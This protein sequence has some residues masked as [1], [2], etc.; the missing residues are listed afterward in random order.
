MEADGAA[1]LLDRF[2][3]LAELGRGGYGRVV[4]A[5]DREVGHEVALKQLERLTPAAIDDFKREFRILLDIRHPNIVRL[6]ELIELDGSWFIAQELV[7]GVDFH[8]FVT[9]EDAVVPAEPARLLPALEQLLGALEALHAAGVVHRD[10]K[11]DNV[12]VT[13]SGRVVLL[14]FGI[15][16]EPS[17][18]ETVTGIH[19]V[20]TPA[21]MAPEQVDGA[22]IKPEADMYSV[23]VMLFEALTGRLPFLGSSMEI[24]IR[25][26][27]GE[28]PRPSLFVDGI[29]P[30]LE[31][32]CLL[33]LSP[34]PAR[35]PGATQA[36][37]RLSRSA[38]STDSIP[39]RAPLSPREVFVGRDAEL[40]L[41]RRSHVE[42]CEGATRA[43]VIEGE[44][45]IGK[46]ALLAEFLRRAGSF[47][48]RPL[49]AR[50][51]CHAA[52]QLRY[53]AFDAVAEALSRKLSR[54]TGA[55][56]LSPEYVALV[57]MLFPTLAT[58]LRKRAAFAVRQPERALM[59]DAFARLLEQASSDQPLVIAIDDLQ[60]SDGDSL[61]LLESLLSGERLSNLL[62]VFT[63]RP[64]DDQDPRLRGQL[65]RLLAL[66]SMRRI[67]LSGLSAEESRT[68]F[69]ASLPEGEEPAVDD[70]LLASTRGHPY[71]IAELLQQRAHGAMMGGSLEAS[72]RRRLAALPALEQEL[73][74]TLAVANAPVSSRVLIRTVNAQAEAVSRA[75]RTLRAER[76]ARVARPGT[77]SSYHD[78]LRRVLLEGLPEARV[79]ALHLALASAQELE[80]EP[81]PAQIAFHLAAAGASER[82]RPWLLR[83][84]EL[85][86]GRAAFGQAIDHASAL[87]AGASEPA[88]R[89]ELLSTRAELL[90][91]LG[92]GREAADDYLEAMQGC[93][94]EAAATLCIRAA[95]QLLRSG[96]VA[97]GLDT[98]RRA[99]KLADLGWSD[100]VVGIVMRALLDRTRLGLTRDPP[101]TRAAP[102]KPDDLIRLEALLAL[103]QPLAWI[104][105]L[106]GVEVT[107]RLMALARRVGHPRYMAYGLHAQAIVVGMEGGREK[108]MVKLL[109]RARLYVE[110]DGSTDARAHHDLT[111]GLSHFSDAEFK[112]AK[113]AFAA[114]EA[115]YHDCPR[116]AWQLANVRGFYLQMLYWLGDHRE[117]RELATR[118]MSDAEQRGD[119][120]AAT[121]YVGNGLGY[122]RH[123]MNDEPD[124]ALAELAELMRPWESSTFG[125]QHF[126][127]WMAEHYI[128]AY[129]RPEETA[130]FWERVRRQQGSPLLLR[131]PLLSDLAR[132]FVALGLLMRR[133]HRPDDPEV[134]R[135][136][137]RCLARLGEAKSPLGR[138]FFPYA[139]AQRAVIEGAPR[140]A[141]RALIAASREA[142][143]TIGHHWL[144]LV[145]LLESHLAG[146]QAFRD[147]EARVV[148]WYRE[149]GWQAPERAIRMSLPVYVRL[150]G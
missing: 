93:A 91:F 133:V 120:F 87:L 9:R 25:K 147:T 88:E 57:I 144:D 142:L 84:L 60:W 100:G 104:D 98:A 77:L 112:A 6:D 45:G 135:E 107:M 31:E 33:L 99:F 128:R 89:R 29:R 26:R 92:R 143:T 55:V 49:I 32:L 66:P 148:A 15:A 63:M 61:Q 1:R 21:Y 46:S 131:L 27:D 41:L 2:E 101:E 36:L 118:W 70:D 64:A 85:A 5:F 68:M 139:R 137:D 123:L 8:S 76:L 3:V 4:R 80:P 134:R 113:V 14:D 43:V 44:S 7:E 140:E 20:G 51:R 24:L 22:I 19:L 149:Q 53:K 54:R 103:S 132:L 11:P 75:T 37:S 40:A 35:R 138:A 18:M 50:G 117:H 115:R 102:V 16:A 82:A 146:P 122:A 141:T 74:Q 130:E 47:T 94:P 42:A 96:E 106:R 125:A 71:F 30:D 109:E 110:R 65:D 129:A 28:P 90:G 34:D 78:R 124:R 114:A 56:Q 119:R 126:S 17:T 48:P 39:A 23:G 72:L 136:L 79:K 111:R 121:M 108:Q 59:F 73:L 83:A 150:Q 81:D 95:E 116:E 105:W 10:I 62:F 67:R 52:E 127:A 58:A 12:R 145:D 13:E 86:R 38:P 97:A 69:A